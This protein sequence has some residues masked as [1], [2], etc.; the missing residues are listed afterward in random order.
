V[1]ISLASPSRTLKRET[2]ACAAASAEATGGH[3]F[4]S[5]GQRNTA[6]FN[7]FLSVFPLAYFTFII[8]K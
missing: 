4:F 8:A 7:I 2:P 5:E 6:I 1:K 3:G